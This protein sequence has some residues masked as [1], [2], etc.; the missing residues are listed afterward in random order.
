MRSEGDY[1]EGEGED[2]GEEEDF[3]DDDVDS[4]GDEMMRVRS[5]SQTVDSCSE[6]DDAVVSVMRPRVAKK[7]EVDMED[8]EFCKAFDSLLTENIAVI[9]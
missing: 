2:D 5:D 3:N 7:K 1:F 9:K 4:C 8:D 6:V